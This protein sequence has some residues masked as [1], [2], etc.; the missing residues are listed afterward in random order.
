MDSN[1]ENMVRLESQ[2]I[3]L[4]ESRAPDFSDP[5]EGVFYRTEIHDSRTVLHFVSKV[6]FLRFTNKIKSDFSLVM[7]DD[8]LRCITHFRGLKCDLK[9]D[10][11]TSTVTISGVGHKIWREDFFPVVA[12]I[13]FAQF[14]KLA[15]SQVC[16]SFVDE[17]T[18]DHTREEPYAEHTREQP[19]AEHTREQPYAGMQTLSQA[20]ALLTT[21]KMSYD[22]PVYTSTPIANRLETQQDK[23]NLQPV[24]EIINRLDRMES[25]LKMFKQSVI[26]S[27]EQQIQSL[28][29]NIFE[30]ITKIKP[31]QTYAAAVQTSS[32]SNDGLRFQQDIRN[33]SQT[34]G[35]TNM[36]INPN[37]ATNHNQPSSR[38]EVICM[39]STDE[40]FFNISNSVLGS[41]QTL[42][43]T[44]HSAAGNDRKAE[45]VGQP[46]PVIITNRNTDSKN[47]RQKN[48]PKL[49]NQNHQQRVSS[50]YPMAS[51]ETTS[52][53]KLLLIGDSILSGVNTKGLIKGIQKHS[54]G[55]ATVNDL[56][57][58]I[59]VY[60]MRNFETCIIYIGGNDCANGT[61]VKTFVDAYDQLLSLIKTTNPA[62]RVYICN[63]APRGDVDVTGFNKG[64][65]RLSKH[66]EHQNVRCMT[67][68]YDY[69]VAK[70]YLPAGRYFSNDGIHLSHSGIKRLLDAI[71]TTIK[72]VVD[73]QLCVFA[74]FKT[75]NKGNQTGFHRRRNRGPQY[76]L[77]KPYRNAE[78]RGASVASGYRNSKKQCFGCN[79]VGHIL[80]ECWNVK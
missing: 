66:W 72:I 75:Q 1:D 80:A 54:K 4:D 26:S 47:E 64:I 31:E 35:D 69:F 60:D 15:D 28:K 18:T 12:R 2:A 42:V 56:I 79:M 71:N 40:G 5:F 77:Y 61:D 74:S 43:K 25:D 62:C 52:K 9:I 34:C 68:T 11:S 37:N 21:S 63:I 58:E 44:V 20:H 7:E 16:E 59:S 38:A 53:G 30:M 73:Y 13:L 29:S 10:S 67:H 49:L 76:T 55:G 19:Y 51:P 17:C 27:V 70:N 24:F 36:Q 6:F 65:D 39:N 50:S 57:E 33:R 14:V 8:V 45:V 48:Y 3:S 22:L 32:Q 23:L 41:S 46:V 78:G